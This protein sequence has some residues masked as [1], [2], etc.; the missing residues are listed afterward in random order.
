ML[1]FSKYKPFREHN[2]IPYGK[3]DIS[4]E[5]IEA[6]VNVLKS[7]FLTQGKTVPHFEQLLSE[8]C[9]AKRG[10][11]VNS[12]TSALHIAC[13]ALGLGKGDVLW[14]TT[15]TF[16]ASGNCA[17]YCGADVDLVDIDERT[18]NMS[19]SALR[20]K[21]EKAK[22]EN[23]LP[24][25]VI[26]V[27]FAGQSCEMR[28]IHQLSKEYG[29]YIIEDAS[30]AVGASYLDKKIG[31]CEYSDITI[32]SFHPVKIITTGEGGMALTNNEDL[33]D[34]MDLL[35]NHGINRDRNK[36]VNK[37]DGPWSFEQIDLGLNYRM[38]DIGASLGVSQ[39]SRLDEFV[40]KRREIAAK[41]DQELKDL[42]LTL[43][44]Q[45]PN[46]DSSFHLYVVKIHVDKLT[47]ELPEIYETLRE[48][49]VGVSK[50][51]IPMFK[52]P[53]YQ[54]MGFD[55]ADFPETMNYYRESLS[56]PIFP[57]FTDEEHNF[58]IEKIKL[59]L[60]RFLRG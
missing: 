48:E 43:P 42:P 37:I 57:L 8:Y 22:E 47:V 58:V 46:C 30:H 28:E 44:Y 10:I 53:Y 51:Y 18:Y 38:T 12:A 26:P 35:R 39:M 21:L 56:L 45:D 7:N 3:Q 27:H 5:D 19:L 29:F 25:I 11:C 4:K 36:M 34:K 16:V 59:V 23:K 52:H 32:F 2:M 20:T 24:K 40:T 1:A 31:C 60:N 15:N 41:Y 50:H 55:P 14:T 33:A 49:G 54:E 17:L 9:G 6:V 13:R